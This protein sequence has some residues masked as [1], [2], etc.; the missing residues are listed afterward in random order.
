MNGGNLDLQKILSKLKF[1]TTHIPGE[2]HYPNHN[3]LGP[4]SSLFGNDGREARLN[5][6]NTPKD[7]SNP[8]CP[9]DYLAYV[10]DLAYESAGDD[11]SKKHEA[12]IAM[13]ESLSKLQNLKLPEKFERF[14]V[15]KV[16]KLKVKLGLGLAYGSQP[17]ELKKP[18]VELGLGLAKANIQAAESL[19][20]LTTNELHKQFRE[21]QRRAIYLPHANH[22]L[23]I[24]LMELERIN[25]FHYVLTCMDGF[26]KFAW[27]FP[28]K[29]KESKSILEC[30]R[31]IFKSEK[32]KYCFSDKGSEFINK[33]VQRFF[34]ENNCIW[35]STQSEIKCSLIE[36]FNLTIRNKL[37]KRK[38]DLELQKRNFNWMN[39]LPQ[40]LNDYNTK[41]VHSSTGFTPFESHKEENKDTIRDKFYSRFINVQQDKPKFKPGD[42]VRLYNWKSIFQKKSGQ[43]FTNEVFTVDKVN[44]TRPITYT[45]KDLNNEPVL[46]AVYSFELVKSEN[47]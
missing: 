20:K 13:I 9:I 2:L 6:D 19:A 27:C 32:Y 15:D 29:N 17:S 33:D 11:L 47:N 30:L 22:T 31:I 25:N 36:R 1:T 24:D 12:D 18:E 8:V 35:Y 38:T 3:F 21:G 5:P 7:W 40:L 4:G 44:Q 26:S 41:D 34:K 37:E 45:L 28:L 14:V 10:H 46:G 42:H 39:E 23:C 16:L 43:R